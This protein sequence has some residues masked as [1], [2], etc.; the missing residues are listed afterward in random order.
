MSIAVECVKSFN[1]RTFF[2]V[3]K[4][5]KMSVRPAVE[6]NYEAVV[7]VSHGIYDGS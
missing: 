4:M 3:P 2:L 7:E 5:S 6:S 1:Y